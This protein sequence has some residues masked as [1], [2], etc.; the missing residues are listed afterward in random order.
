MFKLSLKI[1]FA[2]I[3][4]AGIS[5]VYVG[6]IMVFTRNVFAIPFIISGLATL[7]G[8]IFLF[9]FVSSPE[10]AVSVSSD[11]RDEVSGVLYETDEVNYRVK[12]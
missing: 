8:V 4:L 2:L 11:R 10:D 3:A 12:Y 6:G 5:V 7:V 1:A 9:K